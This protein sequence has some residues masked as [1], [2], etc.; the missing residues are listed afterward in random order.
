M[1]LLGAVTAAMFPCGCNYASSAAL[2][3]VVAVVSSAAHSG[4]SHVSLALT[5]VSC[6][7]MQSPAVFWPAGRS[8]F[9]PA[10]FV[11]FYF[12]A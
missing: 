12:S 9:D 3:V 10:T 8:Q 2:A 6:Y 1:V 4:Y 5:I 11:L 7:H